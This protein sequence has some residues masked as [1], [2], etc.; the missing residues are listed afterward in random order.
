MLPHCRGLAE[1]GRSFDTVVAIDIW[2]YL[3]PA[4][5][6]DYIAA[7]LAAAFYFNTH[8]FGEV[9]PLEYEKNRAALV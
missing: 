2:E 7:V 5:L 4:R 6:D 9:F 8:V 1:A 3:H